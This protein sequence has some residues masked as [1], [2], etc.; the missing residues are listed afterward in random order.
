MDRGG[1]TERLTSPPKTWLKGSC[2]AENTNT[3]AGASRRNHHQELHRVASAERFVYGR[4]QRDIVRMRAEDNNEEERSRLQIHASS[5][6][7]SEGASRDNGKALI[8]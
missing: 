6:R 4:T 3:I 5:I 8:D 1:G 2:G 7:P